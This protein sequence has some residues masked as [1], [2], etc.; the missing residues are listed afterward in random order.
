ME[1][2]RKGFVI[3]RNVYLLFKTIG[4]YDNALATQSYAIIIIILIFYL[5]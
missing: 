2:A 3:V 1:S 4:I 5:S